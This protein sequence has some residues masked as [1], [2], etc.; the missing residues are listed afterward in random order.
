[1]YKATYLHA[2]DHYA[3]LGHPVRTKFWSCT[4][5][6]LSHFIHVKNMS[7]TKF[8]KFK[9][10]YLTYSNHGSNVIKTKRF[11][12]RIFFQRDTLASTDACQHKSSIA[13]ACANIRLDTMLMSII[14]ELHLVV[15]FFY[16][17]ISVQMKMLKHWCA[18]PR[19]CP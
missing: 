18:L 14:V 12:F 17:I 9:S 13:D 4:L 3:T 19:H 8:K 11:I 7:K 1:M 10:L 15:L 16:N 6:L 5:S 2:A